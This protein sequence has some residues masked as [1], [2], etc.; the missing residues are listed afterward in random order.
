MSKLLK[1]HEKDFTTNK[2]SL[3]KFLKKFDDKSVSGIN[4]LVD[5]ASE[6][7]WKEVDCLACA[8]CWIL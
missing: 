5:N 7:T 6:E 3:T 1:Q 8:N 4:A 2:K